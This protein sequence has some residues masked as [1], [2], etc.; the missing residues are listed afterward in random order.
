MGLINYKQGNFPEAR[1]NAYAALRI[2]PNYG[3]AYILIGDLYAA[4]AG[5][6]NTNDPNEIPGAVYW[7]AADKSNKAAAVDPSVAADANSRRSKLPG[8]SFEAAFK[9]GYNKGQS[10]RVG[11]WV[12][13]TTTVR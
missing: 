5:R 4:S 1:N 10:Y 2:N 9:A 8:V 13:E 11:C 7:A 3:K 12:Q 6:C